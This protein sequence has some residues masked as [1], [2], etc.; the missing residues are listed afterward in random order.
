VPQQFDVAVIGAGP[1]GAVAARDLARAGARVALVDGSH[2][3]EKA[4]G[5]GVTGRALELARPGSGDGSAT[6]GRIVERVTFESGSR[7]AG[8][9]LTTAHDLRVFS[10]EAFDAALLRDARGAGAVLIPARARSI[11]RSAGRWTITAG[12]ETLGASWVLGADGAGG[13][14]RKRVFRAFERDQ[15]SIAAGSYVD[16]VESAEIAIAFVDAP[17]GYLWSFPRPGHLAV[18]ACAQADETTTAEMHAVTDAWLDRYPAARGRARR[19]YAWP[20]PSLAAADVD[21]EQPSGDGWLLLGDAA[22]LVDPITREGIFFALRS[23]ML[24]AHALQTSAPARNYAAAVRDELHGELRRAARLKAGFYRPRFTRLLI[25]A[26]DHSDAI[27][28]VMVDL[29]AGRQPYAGLKRR[30][31]STFE[32][33]LMLKVLKSSG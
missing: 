3:R 32:V 16:G 19:R 30:L 25:E 10:R 17:R 7:R 9:Q 15:I 13:I 29:V 2:P 6:A 33:G 14:V 24:A 23:G 11:D 18:G 4:C 12:G 20:I 31:I 5:G 21:A 22:G 27:R 26:L 1:A 8:V 28:A